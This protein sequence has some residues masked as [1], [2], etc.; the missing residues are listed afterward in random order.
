MVDM[1]LQH[2]VYFPQ[3]LTLLEALLP[4]PMPSRADLT[5]P[6]SAGCWL[7]SRRV[8]LASQGAQQQ[9]SLVA[10]FPPSQLCRLIVCLAKKQSLTLKRSGSSTQPVTDIHQRKSS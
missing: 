7:E 6:V 10:K 8:G 4:Q 9:I 3:P 1:E 2:E 5:L